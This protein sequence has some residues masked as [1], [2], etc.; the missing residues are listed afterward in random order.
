MLGFIG[1]NRPYSEDADLGGG[2]TS[3]V[4]EEVVETGE[5]AE[6]VAEPLDEEGEEETEVAD[7]SEDTKSDAAFAEMRRKLEAAQRQIDEYEEALGLWFDGDNK[8][9][10]AHAHYED[11]SLDEAIS[12]MEQKRELDQLR[13]EKAALEEEKNQLEF[14]NLRAEDLKAIKSARP[15]ANIKDVLELGEDYFKYRTMDIDPVTAYDA[16]QLKKGVPPKPMGKA[17]T[18]APA[19]TGFYTREEV[20]AMS[21]SQISKNFDKI[22]ESMG[23]W[24]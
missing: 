24:K 9:A 1:F 16:L 21:P 10:Q 20:Q 18:G 11:I 23:K 19:K 14:D 22:R 7:P 8:I 15:D 4:D 17:K 3:T 6:D 2:G 12:N 13:A 5:E